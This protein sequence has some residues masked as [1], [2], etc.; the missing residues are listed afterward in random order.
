MSVQEDVTSARKRLATV[1]NE[2]GLLT[3]RLD[4]LRAERNQVSYYI[5]KYTQWETV[6]WTITD[7]KEARILVGLLEKLGKT[8]RFTQ[9]VDGRCKVEQACS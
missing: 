8:A 1:D 6:D 4:A 2:I 7:V 3:T 9:L 5:S